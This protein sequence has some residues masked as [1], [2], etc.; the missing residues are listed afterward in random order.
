[1]IR[2]YLLVEGQTEEV[3]VK[4]ILVPHYARTN[5]FLT[6]IIVSTRPWPP[7]WNGQLRQG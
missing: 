3:F 2:V 5:I 6:P 1:M 7:G 4:E